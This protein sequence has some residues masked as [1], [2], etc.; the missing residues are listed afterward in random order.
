MLPLNGPQFSGPEITTNNFTPDSTICSYQKG[1]KMLKRNT[2]NIWI[3]EDNSEYMQETKKK[4]GSDLQKKII[5]IYIYICG[6]IRPRQNFTCLPHVFCIILV[7]SHKFLN[8]CLQHVLLLC[9]SCVSHGKHAC[10]GFTN[11]CF[12]IKEPQ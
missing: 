5:Y 6:T 1:I 10:M 2:R 4:N 11:K 3:R 9:F 12:L 7:L 8:I